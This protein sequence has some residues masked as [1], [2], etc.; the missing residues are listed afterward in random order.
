MLGYAG[1][2][3]EHEYLTDD[4][5]EKAVQYLKRQSAN[6]DKPF[7]L[8]LC[9]FAVQTPIE[10]PESDVAYFEARETI[11]WNGHYDATYAAMIK[12][13]D[14]GI[15]RIM[16]VLKETGLEDKTL[17]VFMSD[18]GGWS[19]Q[20]PSRDVPITVNAPLK[21]SK[22]HVFEGGI[23][24]PLMFSWQGRLKLYNIREDISETTN[25][26]RQQPELTRALFAPLTGLKG[27]LIISDL[28]SCLPGL[29]PTSTSQS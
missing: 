1:E 7:F 19:W 2:P 4:L 20:M 8:Y 12:R 25:L 18:N 16:D 14:D 22:A 13:L 6:P 27:S 11:G 24:V 21:G 9:H 5:T 28:P 10:A 3:S 29:N 17:I 23:R 26:M 15:G